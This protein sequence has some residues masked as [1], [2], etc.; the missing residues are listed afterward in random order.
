MS[1][2]EMKPTI[3]IG[4]IGHVSQGKSSICKSISGTSTIKFK[5]EK[6]RNI[7]IKLGYAN[8]KIYEKN[9]EYCSK[10]PYDPVDEG[11]SLVKHISFV[12]TPGHDAFMS[13]M[14]SG[15]SVMDAIILIVAANEPCPQP[16]TREHLMAVEV[17]AKNL[18]KTNIII[19]QNKIDLVTQ[20]Q[21]MDNYEQIKKF[22][23]GT[24]AEDAPIIP[25]CAVLGYN[26]DKLCKYIATRFIEP[27]EKDSS[28]VMSVIRSF[29]INKPGIKL[30]DLKG[31]V[32]GGTVISGEFSIGDSIVIKPGLIRKKDGTCIPVKTKII[33][34]FTE[35][36]P[37]ISANK[38][39]LVAIGTNLDPCLTAKDYLVGN[40]VEKVSAKE[41]YSQ[42]IEM[43]VECSMFDRVVGSSDPVTISKKDIITLN[44][45]SSL[46]RAKVLKK[47]KNSNILK[48]A[49]S[50]PV[51]TK[52][53]NIV[54][55]LTVVNGK[56]RLVG[57]GIIIEKV[58]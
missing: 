13:T 34:L 46:I 23:K 41:V 36:T 20:S 17:I 22:V 43:V 8:A 58:E 40:I 53:G 32:I 48:L 12:D 52:T 49:L 7:T 9:G 27:K 38:G 28:S 47:A 39:G 44:I 24:I 14:I 19:A 56:R 26:M 18:D 55:I 16:Q 45:G 10:G 4:M 21:A 57:H 33:S 25:L 5:K 30:K 11:F 37:L 6:E 3:N 35:K 42:F 15:A 50:E 54:A 1:T 2:L 51:Y 31:G 29:D